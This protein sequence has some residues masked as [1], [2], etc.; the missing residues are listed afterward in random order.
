VSRPAL[1][2]AAVLALLAV[3]GWHVHSRLKPE[4][5]LNF[6]DR[7]L[8]TV[9]GPVQKAMTGG[10]RGVG[11]FFSGYLALVGVEK[12]N[13]RLRAALKIARADLVEQN[14]LRV[15]NERLRDMAG[16][17]SRVAAQT[18]GASVIGR[19][20]SAR[21]RALRIDRGTKDGIEPGMAVLGVEGAVGRILR[22]GGSFA[23]VLLITDGLSAVGSVVQRS[24]A[25]SVAVG[26][27]DGDL[28]LGYIRRPDLAQVS[29]GDVIVTSGEDGV[30][31][32]GVPIG[33]VTLAQ[34]AESGLFVNAQVEPAVPLDRVSEV[35]VVLEPGRGIQ[36]T[37]PRG[38]VVAGSLEDPQ[39]AD[40]WGPPLLGVGSRR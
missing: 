20:T 14:E 26:D 30:F 27:G 33:L 6:A 15:Q 23:D 32:E 9:T 18:L 12:E 7:A 10:V 37:Y 34:A 38:P 22:A 8:L 39:V 16:L 3:L 35:L 5:D 19:G 21:F 24:R 31:P 2:A 40:P 29:E 4:A 36:S 17:K 25:R 28:E 11:G 1:Q 13:E